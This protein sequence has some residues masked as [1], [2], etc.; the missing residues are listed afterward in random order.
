[1]RP[2][3]S[4]C[5]VMRR[6]AQSISNRQK[7]LIQSYH[8]REMTTPQH[9]SRPRPIETMAM[10]GHIPLKLRKAQCDFLVSI[11]SPTIP[12]QRSHE[13]LSWFYRLCLGASSHFSIVA[14]EGVGWLES[15]TGNNV[16]RHVAQR[17]S[18]R[19]R[20]ADWY[21][22][23]L[24]DDLQ[25]RCSQPLPSKAVILDLIREYFDTFNKALP[26]P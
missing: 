1:M 16:W 10:E 14:P 21:P 24:Q 11:G 18:T 15:K 6:Q 4:D 13:W 26:R 19:W 2:R 22:R 7:R 9:H 3:D 20:L 5:W 25:S 8:L 23:T 17:N 12:P